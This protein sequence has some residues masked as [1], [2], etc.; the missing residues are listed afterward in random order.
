MISVIAAAHVEV[1]MKAFCGSRHLTPAETGYTPVE[2]KA[3]AVAWYL[4]KARF[5]LLRYPG[6]VII[7]DHRPLVKATEP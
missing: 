4:R 6:L 1:R 2:G 3:L 7:T 5:F